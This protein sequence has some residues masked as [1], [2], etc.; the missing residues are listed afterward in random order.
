M[1]GFTPTSLAVGDFNQDGF[2]D[3][4]VANTG[5]HTVSIPLGN[6]TGGF[7]PAGPGIPVGPHRVF[8]LTA[9]VNGDG[10]PDLAVVNEDGIVSIFLNQGAGDFV[11]TTSLESG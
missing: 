3:L 6:G 11:E 7:P 10:K 2:L 4:A 8:V 9:D 1:A 5:E